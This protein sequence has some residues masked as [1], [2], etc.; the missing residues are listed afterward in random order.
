MT[1]IETL[2]ME[3]TAIEPGQ[4]IVTDL[5]AKYDYFVQELDRL[6]ADYWREF[7]DTEA[8]E[9]CGKAVCAVELFFGLMAVTPSRTIDEVLHKCLAVAD[10]LQR[11]KGLSDNEETV[12]VGTLSE[13]RAIKAQEA[14]HV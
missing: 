1:K 13:Y 2:I 6:D 9:V 14:R 4:F 7:P 12:L 10:E 3:T 5:I 11:N 8:D